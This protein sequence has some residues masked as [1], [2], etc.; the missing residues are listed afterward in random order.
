MKIKSLKGL[1]IQYH[2]W[3]ERLSE[4]ESNKTKLR[5]ISGTANA[6]CKNGIVKHV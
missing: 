5:A 6:I 3:H 4:S 2:V 1:A